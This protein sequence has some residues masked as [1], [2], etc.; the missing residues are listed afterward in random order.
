M[1][2]ENGIIKVDPETTGLEIADIQQVL[3]TADGDLG[4]LCSDQ[5]WDKNVTPNVI[6]RANRTNK[7]AKFKPVKQSGLD[8][9]SQRNAD[10]TWKTTA[11]WWKAYNGQCGLTFT[12][13]NSL[14]TN[15]LANTGFLHDLLAG[16]LSW[17]YE[18]PTGGINQYPYRIFDFNYYDHL[19]PKPVSGVY[20]NLRIYGGGK[21]T[22]Q[23][24]E[25]RAGEDL[26]IQMDDL[27]VGNSPVSGW[28]VGVLIW[29]SN[30]QFTFAFSEDT[31]GS[32]GVSVE[33]SNMTPYG[34]RSATIVPFLS[35]VRANQG[36]DPG[37]GTFISCDTAPQIVTIGAEVPDVTMT[38]DAQWRTTLHARVGYAVNIINNTGTQVTITNLVIA[39]YDGYQNVD[40]KNIG[41]ITIPAEEPHEESG[42]LLLQLAY[43]P[44]A[45]YEV[46]VSSSRPEVN[47]RKEVDEPRNS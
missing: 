17:G 40:T 39:L 43:D 42:V 46:V 45:T 29:S 1:A 37:A 8:F 23:L 14:G 4:L 27:V 7:W 26:G 34:G 2:H 6:I 24:D 19:A 9:G 28:Y 20:D 21:L 36:L 22:V 10:F 38:I 30:S 13:Y 41:S 11:N 35:S 44:T 33:F 16:L 12:T 3:G 31:I 25:G 18:P 47:G 5:T 15:T 32:G